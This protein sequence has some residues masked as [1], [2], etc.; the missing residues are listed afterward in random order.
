MPQKILWKNLECHKNRYKFFLN[1]TKVVMNL[2]VKYLAEKKCKKKL[3][4]KKTECQ[5]R[6]KNLNT[7]NCQK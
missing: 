5:K 7:E 4:E 2:N 3:L 6:G 1:V